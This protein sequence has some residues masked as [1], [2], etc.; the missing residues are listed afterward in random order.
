VKKEKKNYRHYLTSLSISFA[1][2]FI[3]FSSL[4]KK[5]ERYPQLNKVQTV[6]RRARRRQ[7]QQDATVLLGRREHVKSMTWPLGRPNHQFALGHVNTLDDCH[8]RKP[9]PQ[10]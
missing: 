8:G 10:I 4:G 2:P 7:H 3:R 9:Q 5:K 1:H 6:W